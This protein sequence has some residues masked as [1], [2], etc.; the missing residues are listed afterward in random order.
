MSSSAP[1]YIP[2]LDGLRAVSIAFVFFAHAGVS[3]LIP[4]GF[5]VTVF[6][7]LSGY[8]IT[9]LL[10]Q[11]QASHGFIAIRAFYLRRIVRLGPPLLITLAFAALLVLLGL[12][13]GDL[14]PATIASQ[15]FFYTNYFNLYGPDVG[16]NVSGLGIL[17]SLAVEEHFYLFYPWV[18]ILLARGKIGLNAIAGLIALILIWRCICFFFLGISDWEIYTRTD[19]RI[20]S[21]LYGCLLALMAGRG[22]DRKWFPDKA[23]YP[24]IALACAVLIVT[25]LLRDPAFRSTIRYSLQGL[26]LMPIFHFAVTR[27]EVWM[28]RPLNW[29]PVRKIGQYSYTLYLVHFVIIKAMILQNVATGN[30]LV[31][32]AVAGALSIAYA[33]LVFEIA[34]KPLKPLRQR[35]TGH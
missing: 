21:M 16:N 3:P 31:F 26:A 30:I 7:F 11:E 20:D 5:G 6:F 19:T 33:A 17:W 23:M 1:S 22:L 10:I 28:F 2:S 9:S 35:L 14:A 25:F 12:A 18:F 24:L 29:K 32:T 8:L 34:E 4:G 13:N 15:I 27:H